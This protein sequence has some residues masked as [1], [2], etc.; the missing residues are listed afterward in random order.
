MLE[1]EQIWARPV[2]VIGAG[3]MGWKIALQLGAHGAVV[4]LH[5][6]D[7][8]ALSRALDEIAKVGRELARTG[9]LPE[10]AA[11]LGDRVRASNSLSEAIDGCWYVIEA[12]PER[13]DLKQQ[14]FGE[15][16]AVCA[17]DTILAT[18]SSSFMSRHLVTAIINPSRLINSHFYNFPWRRSGVELMTCGET[19]PALLELVA[20]FLRRCGL[21]P[22]IAK[23]ESTG[24]VFN[25][26]WHAVKR[27][28]LKVVAEGVATPEE[29]D[30]L[31]CLSME[32]R[33][34]P[35]AMMDR[36][37]LDVVLDIERHYAEMSGDPQDDPPEFLVEMVERGELGR[38]SEHGFY[39][40][41]NPAWERAGWPRDDD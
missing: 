14:V 22:V 4:Q 38:K 16:S 34:G 28:S 8:E 1:I 13:M 18:N 3:T 11:D 24:F 29:V 27:E 36:V 19:D 15:L 26:V 30:R 23:A 32:T 21:V 35:F 41:P 12:I 6:R 17:S 37:G 20:D 31:W 9:E 2:A 7:S 5:D 10:R 39:T 33:L 25:R 40:Y